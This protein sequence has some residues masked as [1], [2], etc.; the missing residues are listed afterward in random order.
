[1]VVI[2]FV[3]ASASKARA[4]AIATTSASVDFELAVRGHSQPKFNVSF[5]RA[6]ISS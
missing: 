1:M 5:L 6:L 4:D 2:A 3:S